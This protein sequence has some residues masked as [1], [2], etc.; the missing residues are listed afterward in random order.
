[1]VGT[2]RGAQLGILLKGPEV[3]ES[4]RRVDTIVLDKTGTVTTGD[5][6]VSTVIAADGHD[7]T[8]VLAWAASVEAGSEH[9]I[10]L[11]VVEAGREHVTEKARDFVSTQ[12]RSLRNGGRQ[13]SSG[14]LTQQGHRADARRAR[15]RGG[16][17]G[18]G[19]C[20]GRRR[21]GR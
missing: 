11:A 6:S 17:R 19:W 4:T 8:Q 14:P 5:M 10:G 21:T 18:I 2:G 1:M 16:D 9:P 7:E 3:L 12:R 20:D 13:A 15:R